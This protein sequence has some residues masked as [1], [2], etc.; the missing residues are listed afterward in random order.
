M[1]TCATVLSGGRALGLQCQ[2]CGPFLCA[3]VCLLARASR[4]PVPSPA[5]RS[6][7]RAKTT[8]QARAALEA[9]A[10]VEAKKSIPGSTIFKA[11]FA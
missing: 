8:A 11:A 3:H 6:L 9:A 4:A 5:G 1:P 7:T 10:E 2:A